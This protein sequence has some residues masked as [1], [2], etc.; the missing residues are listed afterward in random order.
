MT[1]KPSPLQGLSQRKLAISLN[2]TPKAVRT[3][4]AKKWLTAL[5]DGSFDEQ[6]ARASYTRHADPARTK[7]RREKPVPNVATPADAKAALSLVRQILRDEGVPAAGP[8]DFEQARTADLILKTRERALRM[9]VDAGELV[10]AAT[11]RKEIFRLSR[12]DRDAL[13]NWPAK[14]AP[15]LAAELGVD[16]IKLTLALDREVRAH[17]LERSDPVLRDAPR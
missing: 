7:V 10:D 14:A 4:I 9:Q 3:A 1:R 8:M 6:T 15:L 2:I 17:L 5:P 11:I 16:Q 12:Q 13:V